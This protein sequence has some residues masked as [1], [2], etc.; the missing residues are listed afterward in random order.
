MGLVHS[1]SAEAKKVGVC[2][3]GEGLCTGTLVAI[4]SSLS[5]EPHNPA[6]SHM[7]SLLWASLSPLES[8]VNGRQ[9]D[10]LCW[11]FMRAAGFLADAHLSL[12]DRIP[13]DFHNQILCGLFS[14]DLMYL[15]REPVVGLRPHTAQGEPL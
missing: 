13:T 14:P 4:S 3:F 10:F 8:M 1:P 12:V 7:T 5:P 2:S 15:A 11:P 6:S 9:G